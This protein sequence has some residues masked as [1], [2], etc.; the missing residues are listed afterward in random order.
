MRYKIL[1]INPGST[2]TKFGVYEDEKEVMV[3]TIRHSAD[4]LKNFKKVSDQFKFRKEL[5]INELKNEGIDTTNFNAIVGRGGIVKPLESGV[6]EVNDALK[7]DLSEGTYGEHASNLGG[8][9]ASELAKEI[10]GCRAFIADPVV[11]DEL[12]D[13]ARLSGLPEMPRRSVFHAL[14][15]KAMARKYSKETS[16]KYEDLN[17][18]IVHMGGGIS[19]GAHKGGRV[20]DVNNA[21]EGEGPFSPERSGSLVA[22]DLAELCFIGKYTLEEVKKM[23]N[24]KGGLMAHL[25]I[26]EAQ[27]AEQR[28][29]DGDKK[30]E[31]VM[32]AMIYNIAKLVGAMSA[33]LQGKI[34]AIIL[35][36]GIAYNQYVVNGLKP[37]ISFLAP[38]TVYPG[39]DELG[40]LAMSGL[41]V[42]KGEE[43]CKVYV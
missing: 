30:A 4:E 13:I 39:E 5:I 29:K 3:K 2:S 38:I 1:S 22:S 21:V 35:T 16:K 11:T 28:I 6:Y 32:N 36:G 7:K 8:L 23:I 43:T 24:G 25:G 27:V 26:N 31:L 34:D 42:L 17:L 9:I 14:N 40:A 15:Q 41:R 20:I 19:V 33:V 18:L 10:P 37:Y 12:Q